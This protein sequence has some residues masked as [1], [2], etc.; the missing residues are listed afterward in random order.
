MSTETQLSSRY[1]PHDLEPALYERWEKGGYFAANPASQAKPYTIVIP[2]PNVTGFLHIGHALNNTLQDILI[3]WRRMQGF[4]ALWVPGTDHA[5][6]ATQHVVQRQLW[7]KENLDRR[8]LGRE[9]FLERFGPGASNTARASSTAQAARLLVDW[10]RTRFTMD[11]GLSRAVL[12]VFKRLSKRLIYRGDYLV[13]WSPKLQTALSDDE[14]VY[15]D[16]KGHLWHIR[17]R[18]PTARD[19]SSLHDAS[20]TMLG[21]TAVAVHTEDERYK[22]LIGREVKLPLKNGSS[23]S[24]PTRSSSAS[25]ARAPSRSPPRTTQRLRHGQAQGSK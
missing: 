9:K 20:E 8:D 7:E 16:V 3:R 11:A 4:D 19:R 21:D 25:S 22:H 24:S 13:N 6:I 17:Y 2:P 15:K 23:R 5:G 1:N 14:V 10:S 18:W 12:T